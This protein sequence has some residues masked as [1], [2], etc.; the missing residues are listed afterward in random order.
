M[1]QHQKNQYRKCTENLFKEIMSEKLPNL[2]RKLDIQV[3][4]ANRSLYYFNPQ[5]FPQDILQ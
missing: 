3:H 2:G 1:G 4:E 5:D